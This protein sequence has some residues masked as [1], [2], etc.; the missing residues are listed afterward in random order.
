MQTDIAGIAATELHGEEGQ[1]V[2]ATVLAGDLTLAPMEESE[3]R[4]VLRVLGR[5]ESSMEEQR[6]IG[7]ARQALDFG[8]WQI[9]RTH[10]EE[11]R[12]GDH[13]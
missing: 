12:W 6:R 2:V 3:P 11:I 5:P 7:Q 10:A 9:D 1:Q 13:A 8:Q 4:R